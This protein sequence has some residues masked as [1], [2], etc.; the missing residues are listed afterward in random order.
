[1]GRKK[2]ALEKL[3]TSI[4]NSITPIRTLDNKDPKLEYKYGH[5]D[6]FEFNQTLTEDA[7]QTVSAGTF[8]NWLEQHCPYMPP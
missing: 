2:E 7:H 4:M 8:H 6:L 5:S 3:F 1:M